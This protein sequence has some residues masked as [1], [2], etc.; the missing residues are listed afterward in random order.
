MSII[1]VLADS[2]LGEDTLP[3]LKKGAFSLCV[4]MAFPRCSLSSSSYKDTIPIT[5]VPLSRYDLSNYL[6]QPHL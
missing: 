1:K 6:S 4:H 2:V 5:R 3:G